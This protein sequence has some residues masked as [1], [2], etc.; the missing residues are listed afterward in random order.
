M[1]QLLADVLAFCYKLVPSY[2]GAI[3]LLTLGVM[4]VLFPLTLK[5]TKNMLQMQQ[6]QPELKRLQ[7]KHK[8]DRQKLNEET[9]AL[10]KESG[11]NP[12]AGCLPML[13]QMPVFIVMYRVIAGM[14]HVAN[15]VAAPRYLDK[16][17]EL[18]QALVR[19]E[20]HMKSFGLD[21]SNSA[22]Q[23]HPSFSTA[24]PF[25]ILVAL[26]IITQYIQTRQMTS[27][28]PASAQTAQ[29]QTMTR[30][31][32]LF[33]GFISFSIPA[34]VNIYFLVSALFRIAQQEAMYRFDPALSQHAANVRESKATAPPIEAKAKD[35]PK[36]GKAE[37]PADK[38]AKNGK[39]TEPKSSGRVTKPQGKQGRRGR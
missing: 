39:A 9:M 37:K 31:M 27:R 15:G 28:T 33:F 32:P 5:S 24:L 26:V 14:T 38:P 35:V 19:D 10:Y 21:L 2:A 34:G 25:F 4:L 22:S 18:Y 29:T 23:H 20:G 3:T 6:L 17:T 8:G 1:F 36:N 13:L 30:V 11:V 12:V 7:Q 16:N